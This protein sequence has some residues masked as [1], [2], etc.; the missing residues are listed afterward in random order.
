MNWSSKPDNGRKKA[1]LIYLDPPFNSK[2]DYNLLF[3][4]PK[5]PKVG[6]TGKAT[7]AIVGEEMEAGY[8]YGEAQITAFEDTWHWGQQAANEFREILQHA[9]TDVAELMRALRSFLKEND[10]M[11]YLTAMCLRL[12]ELHRV[13]KP[14]GNLYLHCDPT[15][16]HYLKIL[17]DAVFGVE[18]FRADIVWKR[19]NSR[20]TAG[21]WPRVHDSILHYARSDRATF[22][23]LKVL[24]GAAK[25]PQTLSPAWTEKSI[26]HLN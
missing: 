23:Q 6:K 8:G 10:M 15:A 4:T 12:L 20:S 18:R 3:K 2:R 26:N 21:K 9:N 14:T 5:A 22:R 24:S 25:I 17:L 19:T 13:L 11:A 16:S 1:R 7:N